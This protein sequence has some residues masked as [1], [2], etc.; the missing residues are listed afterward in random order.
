MRR[1]AEAARAHIH[2]T[3]PLAYAALQWRDILEADV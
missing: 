3:N 1:H 2:A